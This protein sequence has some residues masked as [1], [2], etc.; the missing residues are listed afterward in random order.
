MSKSFEKYQKRRLQ[1]SY[2]SVVL[3]ITLVLLM[4][5][6]LG[7]TV[8]KYRNLSGYFKE[9][10][11]VTLYLKNNISTKEQTALKKFLTEK[12]FTNSIRFVSKAQAAKEF[13]KDIGED[14]LSFLGDNP[15]KSYYEI[16]LKADFVSPAQLIYIKKELEKNEFIEEAAY[17][18]PLVDLLTKN[19]K[20][21]GFWLVVGASVLAFIAVLLLNSSIRLSI[22]SKR[23]TIKTMQMVGATKSFIRRP[24]ILGSM[25]LGLLG[26]FFA[27]AILLGVCYKVN[28][29][30]PALALLEDVKVLAFVIGGVFMSAILITAISA[31]MA[32][33]RFLRL[34][35]DQLYF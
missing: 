31:F 20:T 3:S 14:F 16:R 35:T 10:V 15:L 28:D 34:K 26:A 6:F 24:F 7:L 12:D 8:L 5:G 29:K 18:A 25:R 19:I 30:L 2:L 33:Q 27:S 22:Y 9:K 13:S 1:A 11:S 21:I 32:T 23:F 4:V 17:D